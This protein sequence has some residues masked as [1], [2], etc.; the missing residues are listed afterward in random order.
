[1]AKLFVIGTPIGNLQDLS[2]RA[3]ETLKS[4]DAIL[5]EDTRVSVK[6]LSHIQIQK[7]LIA[8]HQHTDAKRIQ[9]IISLLHEEKNLALVT[10]AGT[11][12]ISDPGGK[13]VEILVS[14]FGND[15]SIIPIPGPSALITALS[16][17]GFAADEFIF[18]GFPPNKKGRTK[19]FDRLKTLDSTIVFYESTHRILK[20]LNELEPRIGERKIVVCRELTKLH[21]T[22]YR[23]RVVEVTEELKRG[24]LKGEFVV[25]INRN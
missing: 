4:V 20:T 16:I 9:E 22:T 19:Y 21:E 14:E 12:N 7:P 24:S 18:L 17:S 8:F 1:M 13:L 3:I 25:V 10:D 2:L 11:P 6:L 5:C 23:G 15:L